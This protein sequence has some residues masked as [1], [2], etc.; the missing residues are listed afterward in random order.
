MA[1]WE[2]EPTPSFFP[3]SNILRLFFQGRALGP[4][5]FG[6]WCLMC[7][8]EDMVNGEADPAWTVSILRENGGST[9]G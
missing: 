3:F 4:L 6:G 2:L 8:L 7:L 5:A 1:D 9:V